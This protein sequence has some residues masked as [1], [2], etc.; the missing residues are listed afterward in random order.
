MPH[1]PCTVKPFFFVHDQV[2]T[3]EYQRFNFYIFFSLLLRSA[4]KKTFPLLTKKTQEVMEEV[5]SSYV[6]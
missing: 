5:A 4:E 1:K 2:F 3:L 6:Y